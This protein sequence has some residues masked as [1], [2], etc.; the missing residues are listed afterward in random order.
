M[1][2]ILDRPDAVAGECAVLLPHHRRS[3]GVARLLLRRLL[4]GLEGGEQL[5][6]VGELLVSEL[7]ANAVEHVRMPAGRVIELRCRVAAGHL[8]I[9]VADAGGE[10]PRV[11]EL[12][13]EAESGRG[14]RLVR[15][16]ALAWGCCPRTGGNG[17]VVWAVVGPDGLPG[18]STA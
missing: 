9:E 14:L 2:E 13:V 18:E 1:P 8:R 16:L 7:V 10:L 12:T 11:R 4:E 3:A 5:L 6:E 17:K 15:E